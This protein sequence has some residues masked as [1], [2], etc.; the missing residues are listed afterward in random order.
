M[1]EEVQSKKGKEICYLIAIPKRI[2]S[3][4]CCNLLFDINGN[5]YFKS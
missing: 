5:V 4:I 2:T 1:R 3:C